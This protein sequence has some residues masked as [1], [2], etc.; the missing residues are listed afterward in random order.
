[1]RPPTAILHIARV[2]GVLRSPCCRA[3]RAAAAER[4]RR[5]CLRSLGWGSGATCWQSLCSSWAGSLRKCVYQ[6]AP[7]RVDFDELLF[8]ASA[9]PKMCFHIKRACLDDC[10]PGR[11]V[12]AAH[13]LRCKEWGSVEQFGRSGRNAFT[14][15]CECGGGACW[16]RPGGGARRA[17]YWIPILG[18]CLGGG[19]APTWPN[20]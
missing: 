18:V 5:R 15:C 19:V 17:L 3:C 14:A 16:V 6:Q 13:R 12:H 20:G 9:T 7:W 8:R 10:A 4:F 2:A 11:S 1:M